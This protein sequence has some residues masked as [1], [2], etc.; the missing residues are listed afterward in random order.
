MSGIGSSSEEDID[1]RSEEEYDTDTEQSDV[2]KEGK[3]CGYGE[4]DSEDD[5]DEAR[6]YERIGDKNAKTQI[7]PRGATAVGETVDFPNLENGVCRKLIACQM[8]ADSPRKIGLF[9]C[10]KPSKRHSHSGPRL[11]PILG[12]S[13]AT[14]A[15][16]KAVLLPGQVVE[17]EQHEATPENREEVLL[18]SS[19]NMGLR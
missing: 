8:C 3:K 10:L 16:C 11:R 5:P 18:W 2:Q 1:S 7:V 15:G 14:F 4:S 13:N 17:V 9:T 19:S 12:E 6:R